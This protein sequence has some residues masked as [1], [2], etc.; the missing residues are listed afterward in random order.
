MKKIGDFTAKKS[1]VKSLKELPWADELDFQ[2]LANQIPHTANTVVIR[3]DKSDYMDQ[4]GLY[5][6]ED[7][8]MDLGNKNINVLLVGVPEQPR[9]MMERIKLVPNLV[10][11][12]NIYDNFED[13]LN[14]VK[15]NVEDT[16]P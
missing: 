9:L 16:I 13:C 8:L 1:K 2:E 10:P 12:N 14:W 7:I 5:A 3:M 15:E 6:F 11:E 4:S